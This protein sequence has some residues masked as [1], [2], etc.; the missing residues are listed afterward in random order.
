M[1]TEEPK[2]N[3]LEKSPEYMRKAYLYT[4]ILFLLAIIGSSILAMRI[5]DAEEREQAAQEASENEEQSSTE[6]ERRR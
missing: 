4:G 1:S 6:Q 5:I 2:K 3:R